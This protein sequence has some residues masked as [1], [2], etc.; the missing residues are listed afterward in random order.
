MLQENAMT[1]CLF[2]LHV[3]TKY[4]DYHLEEMTKTLKFSPEEFN[5]HKFF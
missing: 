4:E 5:C 2:S 1:F 3:S